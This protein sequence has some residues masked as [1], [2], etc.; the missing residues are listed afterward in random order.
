MFTQKMNYIL[1]IQI[2][3]LKIMIII[4]MKKILNT[5]KEMKKILNTMRVLKKIP[6]TMMEMKKILNTMRGMIHIHKKSV[7]P[8]NPVIKIFI[9]KF[10]MIITCRST[11][12]VT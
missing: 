6:S 2:T 4:I 3:K 8:A 5:M 11:E 1:R 7:S 12:R 9:R 10:S